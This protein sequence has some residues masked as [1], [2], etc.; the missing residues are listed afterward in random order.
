MCAWRRFVHAFSLSND[1]HQAVAES[2][3]L[4]TE[5]SRVISVL[6]SLLDKVK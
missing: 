3:G 1:I 5:R 2:L 4:Q 6:L